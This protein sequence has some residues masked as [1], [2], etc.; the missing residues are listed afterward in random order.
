[1]PD[2]AV[3]LG[4]GLHPFGRFPNVSAGE[5]GR[6]ATQ[7]AL[8]DAG[9]DWCQIEAAYFS[10]MYLPAT[11]GARTL[12]SLGETGIT[13]CDVEAACA[14]GGVALRQGV[15]S[16]MAG[17]AD[18]V[19]VVGAEKMPRGFMD[20]SMIY[21]DWQIAMGLTVNP[22][23]WALRAQRHMY[24]FGTSERQIAQVAEKNHL[25]STANPYAMYQKHFSV[26]EILNSPLVCDPIRLL[27]ICAPNDGAAAVIIGSARQGRKRTTR[28]VTIASS[29]HGLASFS[30]D[31]RAPVASLSSRGPADG[32]PTKSTSLAAYNEAD[33][34]PE[35]VDCFEVQDTDA[36]CEIEACEDLGLC[37]KGEGGTLV[38]RGITVTG[39][40]SPV[41][42][43]GGLISKGEPV[44]A[45]HLGQVVELVWQ[46]RG[47]AGAR[48]VS[49]AQT[50]LAHVLGAAGNCAI[51]IVKQ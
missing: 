34:G 43:S 23:Y 21:E 18:T 37:A 42:M 33:I 24:E 47:L 9:M 5:M 8:D 6:V 49:G 36:F 32:G 10:S 12:K 39:G 14:S 31:L 16:I 40:S 35:E 28:P 17:E 7:R 22:S 30:A 4:V 2:K 25:N 44:G 41:N 3:I 29:R 20:P 26:D 48:Q 38:D 46:L 45:S 50:A 15:T 11:S 1:M 27:E 13:I 51:T 19:L